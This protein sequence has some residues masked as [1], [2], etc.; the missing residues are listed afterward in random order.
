MKVKKGSR[1]IVLLLQIRRYI[2]MGGQRHFPAALPPGKKAVTVFSRRLGEPQVRSGLVPRISSR[3]KHA[4]LQTK[5]FL[6]L[7]Y[8]LEIIYSEDPVL[9]G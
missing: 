3:I 2:G 4:T 6:T 7:T 1:V 5:Q 8:L 9:L